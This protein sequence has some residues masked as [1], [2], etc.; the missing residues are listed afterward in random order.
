MSAGRLDLFVGELEGFI[1]E[2]FFG[3][4]ASGMK[5]RRL[6]TEGR[7]IA[8]HNEVSRL[9]SEHGIL[10]IVILFILIFKP[11][12]MR[13]TYKNNYYF[14]AFLVFWF[15]TINHSAMRIAA[16]GFIYGLALLNIK[17]EKRPIHRKRLIKNR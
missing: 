17:N 6:E 11:M 7:V 13:A 2:P 8:T 15:A 12:D 3:A 4:G 1:N 16:P 5:E 14:Y 10:G 9:L